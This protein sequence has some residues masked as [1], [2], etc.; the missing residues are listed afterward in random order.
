MNYNETKNYIKRY[1]KARVPVIIIKTV[2]KNR[3]IRLMK[4]ISSETNINFELFQMSQGIT[5][6]KTNTIKSEDKTIMSALDY[7][8][9]EIKHQENCNFILNDIA[10][11]NES[12][13][14]SRYLIDVIEKA[15]NSSA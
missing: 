1:L 8:S 9:K 7:I 11:I 3:A 15:E 6:L 13:T 14:V 10:D 2:E 5:D 4:E 12:T